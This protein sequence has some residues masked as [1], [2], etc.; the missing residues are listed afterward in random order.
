MH[1]R[2]LLLNAIGTIIA[3]LQLVVLVFE[4]FLAVV[5]AFVGARGAITVMCSAMLGKIIGARKGLVAVIANVWAFLSV[6][7]HMSINEVSGYI[8]R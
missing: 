3:I 8:L 4:V 2:I 7:A 5:V 1:I 6:S